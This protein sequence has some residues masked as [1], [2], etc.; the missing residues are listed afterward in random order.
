MPSSLVVPNCDHHNCL[1]SCRKIP[2]TEGHGRSIKSEYLLVESGHSAFWTGTPVH[3]PDHAG[4]EN[5][6]ILSC[7][8]SLLYRQEN[9]GQGMTCPRHLPL[10]NRGGGRMQNS[11]FSAIFFSCFPLLQRVFFYF[12]FC[13]FLLPSNQYWTPTSKNKSKSK[14]K[15]RNKSTKNQKP[16]KEFELELFD[17]VVC[18]PLFHWVIQSSIYFF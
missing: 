13:S 18:F 8:I 7:L 1:E 5:L 12:S 2:I 16:K 11:G 17:S 4:F 6:L 10:G 14:T 15:Q 3:S 9:W